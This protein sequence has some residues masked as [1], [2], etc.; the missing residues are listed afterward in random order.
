MFGVDPAGILRKS[1]ALGHD[2]ESGEQG[3]PRIEYLGHD[4]GATSQAPE[5]QGQQSA[6]GTARRYHLAAGH[7]TLRKQGVEL[8]TGQIVHKQKEAPKVGLELAW[9][10]VQFAVVGHG[11][12]FSN[13]RIES[14]AAGYVGAA[15][16][17][18]P[19]AG[20]A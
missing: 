8:D 7:L 1:G 5:L 16:P 2:V 4:M 17:R 13:R 15:W 14:Y 10:K 12:P 18:R 9:R 6:H 3:Q 20:C 11:G 19:S